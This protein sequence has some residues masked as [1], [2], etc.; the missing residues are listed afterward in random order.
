MIGGNG[1]RKTLRLVAQYA[2]A[3]NLLVPDPGESLAKLAVLRQHC[4]AVGRSYDEIE[5]TSL[6]EVDL[7]EGSAAA[8][9][10]IRGQ[11]DE[12]I[13]HVIVNMANA[14]ELGPVGELAMLVVPEIAE[15]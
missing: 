11:A 2:D 9:E 4:Q 5:K 6:I 1:E 12:G 7:R 13:E 14:H 8:V 10:R 3:C 15:L